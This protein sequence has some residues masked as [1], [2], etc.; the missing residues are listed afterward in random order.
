MF[1][2]IPPSILAIPN[3]SQIVLTEISELSDGGF[4]FR[5]SIGNRVCGIWTRLMLRHGYWPKIVRNGDFV[6][7]W[8]G[9]KLLHKFQSCECENWFRDN[10]LLLLS[11]QTLS[12][13]LLF[14]Y[15]RSKAYFF[16]PWKWINGTCV[17]RCATSSS[18]LLL[19]LK[20]WGEVILR[21]GE[22]LTH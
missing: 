12:I 16:L 6:D 8:S 13:F 2:I 14:N 3:E 9:L 10:S 5:R 4:G 15:S 20:N 11:E 7:Q 17:L 19:S 18:F 1:S 22:T 21:I